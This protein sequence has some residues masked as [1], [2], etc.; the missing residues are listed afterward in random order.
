[1]LAGFRF[2][3]F[4]GALPLAPGCAD[5]HIRAPVRARFLDPISFY[6]S[7]RMAGGEKVLPRLGR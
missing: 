5:S 1:M 6:W 4:S 7:R 3:G 2:L